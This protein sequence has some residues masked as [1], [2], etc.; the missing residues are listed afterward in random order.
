LFH[1]S[2]YQITT[3]VKFYIHRLLIIVLSNCAIVIHN[4]A[5]NVSFHIDITVHHPHIINSTT[6][7]SQKTNHF[8]TS[9]YTRRNRRIVLEQNNY[10]LNFLHTIGWTFERYL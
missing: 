5:N 3:H 9:E 2:K 8:W 10:D 1:K 6:H 4:P 7:V